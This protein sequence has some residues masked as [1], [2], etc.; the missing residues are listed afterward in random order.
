MLRMGSLGVSLVTIDQTS[1]GIR[2]SRGTEPPLHGMRC[3]FEE[4]RSDKGAIEGTV[5]SV[6]RVKTIR[7]DA[8]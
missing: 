7:R 8:G 5:L 2:A 4:S 6:V 3:V 1:H